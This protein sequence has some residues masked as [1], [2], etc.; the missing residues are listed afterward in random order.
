MAKTKPFFS[1]II[2]TLNEEKYLPFLLADLR[3]QTF[4]DFETIVVDAQSTDNTPQISR[5]VKRVVFLTTAQANVGYQRN[6]GAEKARGQYLLFVD[7]DTRIPAYFLEGLKYRISLT[8]P[9]V[10]TTYAEQKREKGSEKAIIIFMNLMLE[11]GH[12]LEAPVALGAMIGCKRKVFLK[13][14]G[15]DP[16]ITFAEDTE[17]V[18]RLVKKHYIF[19][20][21]KDPRFVYSLRRFRREGTLPM[22][23]KSAKINLEWLL[24]GFPQKPIK[25]YPMTGG[26]YYSKRRKTYP[27]FLTRFDKVITR[28]KN[29]KKKD[30]LRRLI[31]SFFLD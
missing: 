31:E 12:L 16:K 13:S 30:A 24:N 6:L 5:R 21:F 26:N 22:I 27:Q 3:R 20:L 28:I 7:A 23:R 29:F 8:R 10:F 15:F 25:D 2:P 18:Q 9:D 14:G 11:A 1:I 17:F 19:R 4:K